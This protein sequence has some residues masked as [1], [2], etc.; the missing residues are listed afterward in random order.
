MVKGLNTVYNIEGTDYTISRLLGYPGIRSL[1]G[2]RTIVG[3]MWEKL[4]A[5]LRAGKVT[6]ISLTGT[7]LAKKRLTMSFQGKRMSARE[8]VSTFPNLR[9]RLDGG[10]GLKE[11]TLQDKLRKFFRQD[12]VSGADLRRYEARLNPLR[13]LDNGIVRQFVINNLDKSVSLLE[14]FGEMVSGP[15]GLLQLPRRGLNYTSPIVGALAETLTPLPKRCPCRGR[16]P[17]SL[18]STT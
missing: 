4:R 2:S 6:A 10:K 3:S 16:T 17:L 13:T 12:K 9:K 8:A 5:L 14:F 7:G 1:L 11:R 15:S 18:K